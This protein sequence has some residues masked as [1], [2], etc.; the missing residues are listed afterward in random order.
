M[1]T[2]MNRNMN[3]QFLV[4][5]LFFLPTHATW[6]GCNNMILYLNWD[7]CSDHLKYVTNTYIHTA[8]I[9][10]PMVLVNL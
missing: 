4:L 9:V 3:T 7:L 6:H 8:E 1:Q 10:P 2:K 5:Q